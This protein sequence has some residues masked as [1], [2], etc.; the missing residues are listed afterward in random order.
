V[1]GREVAK[2]DTAVETLLQLAGPGKR[3]PGEVRL[4]LVGAH[5][6]LVLDNP[7]AR[8]AMTLHM[9]ADLGRCVQRLLKLDVGLVLLRSS[10]PGIFCAGG[11]LGD[12]RDSLGMPESGQAMCE[13]MS[14]ILNQL[15]DAPCLVV[16]VI[17][18]PAIGGGAEIA[19]AADLRLFSSAGYLHFVHAQLGVV[20]GW[21]G[22]AR[23][24]AHCG[25]G[26]ALRLLT[27]GER[28]PGALAEGMGLGIYAGEEELARRI[29]SLSG[30]APAVLRALKA[31][32]LCGRRLSD[33]A[34][35]KQEAHHFSEVW[36]G[37]AHA[38]ALAKLKL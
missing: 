28:C 30:L 6:E 16:A 24:M 34:R 5:A 38:A 33:P 8:N 1:I 35:E 4:D 10:T 20:P 15:L 11:H 23:L 21:G 3:R 25:R 36:A 2:I 29:G 9:M 18:G 17:D 31:Q 12:V 32:I 7:G 13:A 19:V 22:T 37:E 26:Q 27:Y 14:A